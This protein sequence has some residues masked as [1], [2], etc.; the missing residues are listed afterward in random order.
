[1]RFLF[2]TTKGPKVVTDYISLLRDACDTRTAKIDQARAIWREVSEDGSDFHTIEDL[3]FERDQAFVAVDGFTE[4]LQKV[5]DL[6]R[7][8]LAFVCELPTETTQVLQ[9]RLAEYA[10]TLE[11][12]D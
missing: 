5:N 12:N 11:D 6:N 10:A 1:M 2:Q 9:E 7:L 8:M 4:D 3:R